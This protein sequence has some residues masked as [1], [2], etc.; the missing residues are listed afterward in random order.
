MTLTRAKLLHAIGW[1]IM[2]LLLLIG[3]S[4]GPFDSQPLMGIMIAVV[5]V[6]FVGVILLDVGVGVE[7]PDER[8]TGNFYK[9][10]SLLFN[11]IDVALLL[12][13][14]F[15]NEAPLTIPYE[16]ILILIALINIIQDVAFLFYENRSE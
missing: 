2:L 15:G 11:L 10:N 16:Y 1:G 4:Y 14:I 9:A 7:K 13:I 12:Y 6:V 3:H 8:A 5:L